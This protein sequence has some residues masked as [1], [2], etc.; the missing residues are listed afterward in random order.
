MPRLSPIL[1]TAL[2]LTALAAFAVPCT[3]R[4]QD[5]A[6]TND[7]VSLRGNQTIQA[8]RIELLRDDLRVDCSCCV[9]QHRVRGTVRFTTWSAASYASCDVQAASDEYG[10]VFEALH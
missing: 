1:R 6:P 8:D 9:Q 7:P 5:A 10:Q 3:S 2:T 4:A